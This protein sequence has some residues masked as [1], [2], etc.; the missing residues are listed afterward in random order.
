MRGASSRPDFDEEGRDIKRRRKFEESVEHDRIHWDA[1][2]EKHQGDIQIKY[3]EE[4]PPVVMKEEPKAPLTT[5]GAGQK[6]AGVRKEE[7]PAVN[8]FANNAWDDTDLIGAWDAAIEEYHVSGFCGALSDVR[9]LTP[10]HLSPDAE[11]TGQRL[12]DR[13]GP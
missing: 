1:Q 7:T 5:S 2:G 12:E 4:T 11:R 9:T 3:D 10:A 8:L 6:N 13:A